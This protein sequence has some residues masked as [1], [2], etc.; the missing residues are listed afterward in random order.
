MR[1]SRLGIILLLITTTVLSQTSCSYYNRVLARKNLVDGGTAYKDRKFADAEQLFKSAI[2]RDPSSDEGKIAQVFLARTLHSE[3]IANRQDN[4]KAEQAIAEYKKVLAQNINDQSSF[5]AI[6]NL[7]QNL[8]RDDEW[9]TWVTDRT[10]NEQVSAENRSEALTSL[11]AKQYS[12]ANDITDVEPVKKTVTKNGKSEFQ[13]TKPTDP[14]TFAELQK[15]VA[16]G[17]SLADRAVKL[18]SNSD[19]AWSYKANMLVQQMRLAEM[20]GDTAQR[21]A[22]KSQADQAKAR[23]TEL[24]DIKRKQ[25]E[26]EERKKAEEEAAASKK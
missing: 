25:K 26:E 17:S 6:A 16:E 9:L 2:S 8:N 7:L 5:K 14:N 18:D 19:S 21:D 13:F 22:L 3:Y 4:A 10:N 15:C 23:F 20:N 11:A 1:L 12:C 24:A